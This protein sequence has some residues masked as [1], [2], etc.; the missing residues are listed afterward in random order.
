MRL[1]TARLNYLLE[2]VENKE[3]IPPK[4]VKEQ[5]ASTERSESSWVPSY[6]KKTDKKIRTTMWMRDILCNKT[7]ID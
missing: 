3:R 6:N 1:R 2:V 7:T 5:C 4:K